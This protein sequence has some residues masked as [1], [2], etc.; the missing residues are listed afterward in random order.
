[1][2]SFLISVA[3]VASVAALNTASLAEVKQGPYTAVKVRTA[4]AFSPD[5]A[6]TRMQS[7]FAEAVA[8]KDEAALLAL[9][10]P[11]FLWMSSGDLNDQFDFGRGPLDNFK[12][13]FGFNGT[14]AGGPL[15][16][17]LATFA[18]DKAFYVA[19]ETLVCGPTSAVVVDEDEFN[20][21]RKKIGADASV[22]WYYTLSDTTVNGRP[23]G[24]GATVGHV[25]QLAL[26]VLGVFPAAKEGQPKPTATHLQVLLPSG[27]SGWIPIAGALP[28]VTDR[29]CYA[30]TADGEWK[31]AAYDQAD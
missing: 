21:A 30:M 26:P 3:A 25:N 24:M 23:N 22:E 16:D 5:Q 15:W 10:G 27:K 29:L 20:D 19:T 6:F 11:T 1:M 28:L 14:A 9:V 13:L 31:L 2:R 4:Q 7:A 12:A 18:A 17:V 8:A